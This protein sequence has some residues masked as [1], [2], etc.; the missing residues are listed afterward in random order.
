ML[1]IV[2]QAPFV[3]VLILQMSF[4]CGHSKVER[5]PGLV[6]MLAAP[7]GG[8]VEFQ[9]YPGK[10]EDKL[11]NVKHTLETA[12]LQLNITITYFSATMP[13]QYKHVSMPRE[14]I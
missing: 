3:F 13:S 6:K 14:R 12:R 1:P 11:L 8:H 10:D 4:R 5:D 7:C 2:T 9:P